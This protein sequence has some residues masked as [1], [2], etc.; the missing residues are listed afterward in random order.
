MANAGLV[1]GEAFTVDESCSECLT[2]C[3]EIVDI[4]LYVDKEIVGLQDLTDEVLPL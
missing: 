2:A 3:V 4:L 1:E